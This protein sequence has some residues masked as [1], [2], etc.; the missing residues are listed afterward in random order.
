MN[1]SSHNVNAKYSSYANDILEDPE[2]EENE[3]VVMED[4]VGVARHYDANINQTNN[5]DDFNVNLE[6][7]QQTMNSMVTTKS[8]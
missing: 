4:L 7:D 1:T 2:D 5:R 6:I 8:Y 3:T